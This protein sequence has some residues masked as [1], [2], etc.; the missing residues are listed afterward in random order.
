MES[1]KQTTMALSSMSSEKLLLKLTEAGLEFS[2][3]E[4]RKFKDFEVDGE[5]VSAGLT[6]HMIGQLF[7]KSF[8]KQVK[9]IK[10]IQQL[11]ENQSEELSESLTTPSALSQEQRIPAPFPLVFSLPKFPKDV[12]LKLDN[13]EPCHKISTYRH[14]I[15][16]VLHETMAQHTLYPS[17][18]DYVCAVK[19]LISKYP[20][21]RD[22]EGNGYH[23]WHM[24]LKRKFKTERS[25]LVN[26]EEVKKIKMKYGHNVKK[27]G[28]KEASCQRTSRSVADEDC[29]SSIGEDA[30]S[31]NAHVKTLQDQY[32]KTQPDA[33][34]V[35]EKMKQTFAWRRREIT[36]GIPTAEIFQKYPFLKTP[37]VLFQE[38]GRMHAV[39]LSRCFQDSFSKIVSNVLS[40]AKGKSVIEAH[41]MDARRE[42][43]AESLCDMDFRAALVLLPV[44]FR[45]K[46]D[47]YVT[48]RQEEPATPYPTVQMDCVNFS[49]TRGAVSFIYN[50]LLKLSCGKLPITTTWEKELAPCK[51][52]W[53][54]IW[55]TIPTLSKNLAHQ[56]IHYKLLHR[57]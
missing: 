8:K 15:V 57:A 24:S 53:D 43:V 19:A 30:I 46:V 11:K 48:I 56:L 36:N 31:I 41:Y 29:V 50:R 3:E 45:E 12:Q 16:R 23:T 26:E 49:Q 34:I 35:D 42:A 5:T 17:N 39:N 55:D 28:E 10:L 37:S 1:G 6:D 13:K 27:P 38:M 22:A 33:A 20:F 18:S 40:L 4:K 21:L 25:P 54:W 2:E 44:I 9:F 14:T 51:L 32:K 47:D 52:N 7:E